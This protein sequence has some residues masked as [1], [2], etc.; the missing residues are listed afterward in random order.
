MKAELINTKHGIA[1]QITA[2]TSED[3]MKLASFM[4]PRNNSHKPRLKILSSPNHNSILNI[5]FV[6]PINTRY[7]NA[8]SEGA[9]LNSAEYECVGFKD[10]GPNIPDSFYTLKTSNNLILCAGS[11]DSFYVAA[12]AD[13]DAGTLTFKQNVYNLSDIEKIKRE[14]F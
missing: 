11:N 14:I 3:Q 10:K 2:L 12:I 1:L 5:G 8:A 4:Q 6:Y 13:T 9:V 7:L